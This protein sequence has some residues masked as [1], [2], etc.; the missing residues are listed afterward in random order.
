MKKG[1][2]SFFTNNI[3]F[4]IIFSV[5]FLNFCYIDSLPYVKMLVRIFTIAF[6]PFV[7]LINFVYNKK[8]KYMHIFMAFLLL[9]LLA[10]IVNSDANITRFF[11]IYVPIFELIIYADIVLNLDAKKGIKRL[12]NIFFLFVVANIISIIVFPNGLFKSALYSN[13]WI[14]GYDNM[15]IMYYIPAIV[16]EK[17]NCI[18]SGKKHSFRYLFL[19]TM[20]TYAVIFC[21]SANSLVAYCLFMFL[22][23][24]SNIDRKAIF[25]AYTVTIIF[26]VLS[27]LIVVFSANFEVVNLFITNILHKSL[28]FSGRTGIWALALAYIAK[29]PFLGY[30]LEPVEMV[31]SKFGSIHATHAHNTILDVMYKGGTISFFAFAYMFYLSAKNLYHN[32]TD[33]LAKVITYGLFAIYIMSIFE[34]REDKF[35][36]YIILLLGFKIGEIIK[37]R[38]VNE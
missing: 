2:L 37:E 12:S 25:N 9:L 33:I 22:L 36:L 14:L 18:L 3:I 31:T 24:F 29:K 20:I 15:H 5:I 34:A 8:S 7:T 10:T 16:L 17:I 27:L 35:G 11:S 4:Y 30:G 6:L 38:E 21:F 1:F 32:R 23:V 19:I 26:S 13:N 28:T